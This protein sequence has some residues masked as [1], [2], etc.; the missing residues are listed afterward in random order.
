M[1]SFVYIFLLILLED[2]SYQLLSNSSDNKVYV[3]M[4]CQW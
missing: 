1:F 3:C 4:L 2:T